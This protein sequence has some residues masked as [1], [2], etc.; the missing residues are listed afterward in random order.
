MFGSGSP[1]PGIRRR[2]PKF[3]QISPKEESSIK[4]L[5]LQA[6][7]RRL[8]S[9]VGLLVYKSRVRLRKRK[10]HARA[11]L[12]VRYRRFLAQPIRLVI[13]A[14]GDR[15]S[16]WVTTEQDF[17]DLTDPKSLRRF[18]GG[19]K[20]QAFLLEHV[21]EHL[22]YE[23]ATRAVERLLN[24]QTSHGTIRIAVPDGN[25]PSSRYQEVAG[26]D[27][28]DGHLH[29]WTLADAE[30]LASNVRCVM[31]AIEYF[32]VEGD[33]ASRFVDNDRVLSDERG[34]VSRSA[35]NSE[36]RAD[37]DDFAPFGYTSLI[38]DLIHGPEADSGNR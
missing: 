10:T 12:Q 14:S 6:L 24:F 9:P 20:V 18:I 36:Q 26:I 35:I 29:L 27:G 15:Y 19:A 23:E 11:W 32:T 1:K 7:R 4:T 30:R 31:D 22:T 8:I 13:G 25:H 2:R 33:F 5:G 17:F 16:G 21:L 38:F 34:L 3:G 28:P 37:H